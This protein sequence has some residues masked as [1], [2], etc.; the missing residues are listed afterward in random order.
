MLKSLI[1]VIVI[2]GVAGWLASLI[3]KKS[4][5]LLM[6]IILGIV[7]GIVG[8]FLLNLIPIPTPFMPDIVRTI[9]VGVL[10]SVIVLAIFNLVKKG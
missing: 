2:G 9:L 7:G 4:N 6:N 3:M 1:I 8:Q 10:G 5:G